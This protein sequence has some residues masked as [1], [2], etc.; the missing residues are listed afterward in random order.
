MYL[1][2]WST[3]GNIMRSTPTVRLPFQIQLFYLNKQYWKYIGIVEVHS[4]PLSEKFQKT[5]PQFY[6]PPSRLAFPVALRP[7]AYFWPSVFIHS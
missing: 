6:L 2:V 7:A 3:A 1:L 4:V 5:G